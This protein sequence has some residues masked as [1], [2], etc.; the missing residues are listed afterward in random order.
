MSR[1]FEELTP[2]NFSFNSPLGWCPACQGLGTEQGTN[3]SAL[4]P[5]PDRTLRD[6]AV[7]TWPSAT[8]NRMFA[9]VL[10]A[11]AKEFGI[12]LDVPYRQ[13]DPRHQRIVLYGSGEQWLSAS[14]P[15]D[16]DS[17]AETAATA[18]RKGRPKD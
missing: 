18:S 9:A 10:E 14:V 7:I 17:N 11:L 13:L 16:R 5:N 15:V 4:I 12:P 3:L 8:A 6:G 2:Q 1:D